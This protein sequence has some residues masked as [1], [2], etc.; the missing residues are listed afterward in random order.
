MDWGGEERGHND[1]L[2][3]R[4]RK[5]GGGGDG[6]DGTLFVRKHGRLAG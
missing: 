4:T 5:Q 6:A 1:R 2:S 3:V